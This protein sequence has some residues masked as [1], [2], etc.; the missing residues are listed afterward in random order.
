MSLSR[1]F[2]NVYKLTELVLFLKSCSISYHQYRTVFFKNLSSPQTKLFSSQQ[3][4]VLAVY[5]QSDTNKLT[6]PT[7]RRWQAVKRRTEEVLIEIK[8][9]TS[10][11]QSSSFEEMLKGGAM[12]ITRR[13]R[14]R[15]FKWNHHLPPLSGPNGKS[16]LIS[17]LTKESQ[18]DIINLWLVKS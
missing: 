11:Q 10:K 13:T 4:K 9:T 3:K 18:S 5:S 12:A 17:P 16:K 15:F 2:T 14:V 1:Y 7:R 8:K 6:S